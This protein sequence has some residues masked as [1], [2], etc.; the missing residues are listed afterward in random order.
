MGGQR[1]NEDQMIN[2]PTTSVSITIRDIDNIY[3][4][5]AVLMKFKII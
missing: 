1:L 5:I 2:P 4:F 3:I